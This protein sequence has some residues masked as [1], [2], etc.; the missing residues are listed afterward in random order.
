M[1][2]MTRALQPDLMAYIGT[3]IFI[4]LAYIT[5]RMFVRAA[6]NSKDVDLDEAAATRL[7]KLARN[8]ALGIVILTLL[9]AVFRVMTYSA[10]NRMPRSD[11]D[12]S[13]VYDTMRKNAKP[14]PKQ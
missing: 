10:V 4:L 8:I 5:F 3:L 11:V 6:V 9:S 2:N 1:E 12:G 14:A 7:R 13:A